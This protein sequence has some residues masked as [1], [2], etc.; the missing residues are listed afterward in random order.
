M[1]KVSCLGENRRATGGAGTGP[2]SASQYVRALHR[3]SSPMLGHF[4]GL[5]PFISCPSRW[6]FRHFTAL[7]QAQ[8][9]CL[10]P[11]R[12]IASK[13]LKQRN[14]QIGV[15]ANAHHRA[16]DTIKAAGKE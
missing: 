7:L 8:S 4:T 2:C 1:R 3:V 13:K 6:T 11:G 10:G 12:H 16:W 15:D 14:S 9:V 5:H